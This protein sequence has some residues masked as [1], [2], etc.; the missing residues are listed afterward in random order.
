MAKF[1]LNLST[2]FLRFI[3][4]PT[5]ALPIL[6]LLDS[7]L[8][9]SIIKNLHRV[10]A[11]MTVRATKRFFSWA[12]PKLT[13]RALVNCSVSIKI[14]PH[15]VI[16]GYQLK[17]QKSIAECSRHLM[18]PTSSTAQL[19]DLGTTGWR[20]EVSSAAGEDMLY[21]SFNHFLFFITL[22]THNFY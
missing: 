4:T 2:A 3:G 6:V 1:Q 22:N 10:M 19:S 9:H 5:T 21:G 17:H 12:G 20:V 13:F 7:L 16:L 11:K 14:L 8:N 18:L 15:R